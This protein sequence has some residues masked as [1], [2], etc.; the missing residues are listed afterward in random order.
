MK[1]KTLVDR[2][3]TACPSFSGRVAGT[4]EFEAQVENTDLSVPCAFV[5]RQA[6]IPNESTTANVVVQQIMERFSVIVVV[7][8][9]ADARGFTGGEA[10]D[11][12]KDELFDGLLGWEPDA[13]H[14]GMEYVGGQHLFMNR[15]RLI[16]EFV[17]ST[18]TVVCN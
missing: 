3:K 7:D 2:I 17:F 11:D 6:D 14:T 8:N 15:A 4:A 13:D 5:L 10:I 9:S 1:V 18:S 12:L 16:H